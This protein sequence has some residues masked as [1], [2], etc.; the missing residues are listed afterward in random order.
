MSSPEGLGRYPVEPHIYGPWPFQG[1]PPVVSLGSQTFMRARVAS[2]FYSGVVGQYREA[3]PWNSQHMMVYGNG[4]FVIDH[5]DEANPDAGHLVAHALLD[6][7][8]GVAV[9]AALFGLA[10]GLGVGLYVLG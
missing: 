1:L 6:V 10:L 8:E 2:P 9:G 4:T 5:V 3:V 7:N